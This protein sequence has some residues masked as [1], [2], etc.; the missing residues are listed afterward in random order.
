MIELVIQ[1]RLL[2]PTVHLYEAPHPDWREELAVGSPLDNH[3]S[4]DTFLAPEMANATDEDVWSR[5]QNLLA[6]MAS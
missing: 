2:A 5:L 6:G 4:T 1:P 3:L